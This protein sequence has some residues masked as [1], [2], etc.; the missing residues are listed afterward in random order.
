[1]TVHETLRQA[2][3]YKR[4]VRVRTAGF[5]RD[6]CP[7]ALGFKDGSPRV[8]A[9]QYSGSSVSGLASGGQWRA[10][11]VRDIEEANL[12]EGRWHSGSNLV[13]K[14]EACLDRVEYSVDRGL[15]RH[16]R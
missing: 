16:R 3:I 9:F 6:I 11:F 15:G 14:V 4:C 13:A 5:A 12:I 8:L 1:M 10:F 2:I 7:H